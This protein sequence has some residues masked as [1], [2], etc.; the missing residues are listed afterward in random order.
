MDPCCGQ[1]PSKSADARV[2]AYVPLLNV[3]VPL[4]DGSLCLGPAIWT[5]A[6]QGT[7]AV[8]LNRDKNLNK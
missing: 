6:G 3:Y 1:R 5:A 7:N 8:L 4:L 2:H